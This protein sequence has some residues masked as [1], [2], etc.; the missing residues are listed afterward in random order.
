MG[1]GYE[2]WDQIYRRYPLEALPWELGRPRK[3]LINLI[4]SGRIKKGKT[5]DLCCGA[6]SNTVYLAQKGF[7]VTAI[8]LTQ[9]HR[10]RQKQS[11]RSQG[12]HQVHGAK[13]SGTSVQGRRIRLHIRHGLFSSRERT[14]Q[15]YVHKR[16][17]Q[18][19]EENRHLLLNLLQL[20]KW[21]GVESLHERAVNTAFF[22]LF[23]NQ[24]NQVHKLD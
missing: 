13:L 7:E 18:S 2:E 9:S 23:H 20:Q 21:A 16:R 3:I 19:L 1:S 11:Q 12:P 10:I 24:R 4:N 6:G 14:G 17:T 22:G 15:E 5:L 8:D